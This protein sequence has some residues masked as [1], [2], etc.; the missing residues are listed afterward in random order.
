MTIADYLQIQPL[1]RVAVALVLG[2]VVGDTLAHGVEAWLWLAASA[3]SLLLLFATRK[4]MPYTQSA[5]VLMAT[6]FVGAALAAHADHN[7]AFPFSEDE[8]V[9]YEAVIADEPKVRG[10]TLQCDLLLTSVGGKPLGS[11]FSVK[12]A[13]LRDTTTGDWRRLHVGSGIEAWSVMQPLENYQRDG[14]FDYVRWLRVRGFRAQTFIF[15]TDWLTRSVSMRPLSRLDRMRIRALRMRRKLVDKIAGQVGAMGADRDDSQQ[16]AVIAAMVLGDKHVLSREIKDAYSVSGASHVL[17]LSGLH[18]G[19]IYAML[20]LLF[21]RWRR[22]W[23]SQALVLVA[24]WAY[25]LL[26]GMG[27]SVMRAAV[28]L[29]IYS[30]CLVARRDKVQVNTLAFAAICLVVANPLCLWDVGFQMSFMAVLAIVIYYR[31]FYHLLPMRHRVAKWAWGMA[32]V[33][34]AAQIGTAPL[35]V[36]YFGRFSCYFL[37]TNFIVVP[38]ATVII[39]GAVALLLSPFP[40]LDTFL[41]RCLAVVVGWLNGALEWMAGLPGACIDNIHINILQ[42]FLVYFVIAGITVAVAYIGKM[43]SMGKLDAAK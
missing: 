32:V 14:N 28:M 6:F 43:S 37:A 12:A 13:I 31:P 18:L 19:I 17:A 20:T 9:H 30:L 23:L 21:G 11:P 29:T 24:V 7:L 27:A 8:P 33:S 36:Y 2:I 22:E 26:V 5:L 34:L 3:I 25:V 38:T 10:R 4:R 35:V 1:L 15:Y 16:Q 42:L 39:Y 40:W 41:A